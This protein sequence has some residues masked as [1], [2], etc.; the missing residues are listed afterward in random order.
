[1]RLVEVD[2]LLGLGVAVGEMGV[3]VLQA[4]HDEEIAVVEHGLARGDRWRLTRWANI[5]YLAAHVEAKRMVFQSD[6]VVSREQR[7]AAHMRRHWLTPTANLMSRRRIGEPGVRRQAP[8]PDQS[9]GASGVQRGGWANLHRA[10]SGFS[11]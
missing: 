8:Q 9:S 4:G 7:T 10:L 11:A 2:I 5:G 3:N 6:G 1:M